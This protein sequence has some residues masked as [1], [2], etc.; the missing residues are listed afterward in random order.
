VRDVGF[1]FWHREHQLDGIY[2][3]PV[4]KTALLP[5]DRWFTKDA[6]IPALAVAS[7]GTPAKADDFEKYPVLRGF[8][9]FMIA[10]LRYPRWSPER[11][12]D[13][14]HRHAR[15]LGLN[16]KDSEKPTVVVGATSLSDLAVNACPA[17]WLNEVFGLPSGSSSKGLA[18]LNSVLLGGGQAPSACYALALSLLLPPRERTALLSKISTP[19]A[20]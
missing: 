15:S 7:V 1:S 13:S 19:L 14:L 9:E 6:L 5:L 12:E 16:T 17:W 18:T 10:F 20:R 8:S 11:I 2:W 3:C 4:H